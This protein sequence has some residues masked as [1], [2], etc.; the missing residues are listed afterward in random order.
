MLLPNQSYLT[1]NLTLHL[2]WAI[3]LV[4]VI[5]NDTFQSLSA[6]TF[7]DMLKNCATLKINLL[8]A[9]QRQFELG[10]LLLTL[11]G[12]ITRRRTLKKICG[13]SNS[14]LLYLA[15]AAHGI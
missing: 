11:G 4:I 13:I 7:L 8:K 5:F 14:W 1:A 15:A 3:S 2:I 10:V 9:A 12:G 6:Y